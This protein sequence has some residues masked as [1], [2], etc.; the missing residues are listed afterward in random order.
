MRDKYNIRR[1]DCGYIIDLPNGDYRIF[2]NYKECTQYA[3]YIQRISVSPGF[4][5]DNE[6][7]ERQRIKSN[8]NNI[9]NDLLNN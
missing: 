2:E 3:E 5:Q 9:I 7:I 6:E 1:E 4:Y 8:R